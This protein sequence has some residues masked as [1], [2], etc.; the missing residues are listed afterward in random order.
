[1][2]Y[3]DRTWVELRDLARAGA[4][5]VVPL[6][7]TEQQSTHLP[8]DFDSWFAEELS[9]AAAA[10]LDRRGLPTLV[11]PVLPF[12]PTPEHRNFGAGYVDLPVSVHEAVVEATVRSVLTQGFGTVVVWRGCGGHDLRDAVGRLRR[13]T[14]GHVTI[15]LPEPPF[16]QLWTACGGP[17]VAAGH[18]DSFTTSI[19]L[20]RRGGDVRTDRIPPPSAAPDW[21]DPN[22]D[23]RDY[24]EAGTIGDVS[25]A[26]AALGA[27]LWAAS[28]DW[29]ANHVAGVGEA[30]ASAS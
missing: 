10:E 16:A 19:C 22:L 28:V 5:V 30:A 21:T 12:G 29:L 6:G 25:A 8:V 17:D 2:K 7:C 27:L 26:S 3:G 1:M 14:P 23:F 24:T 15:D 9:L 11:L 4:A 18:A 20:Y 13:S